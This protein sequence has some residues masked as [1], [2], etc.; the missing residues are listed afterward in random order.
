M[1]YYFSSETPSAIKVNGAFCGILSK[2]LKQINID[3]ISPFIELCPVSTCQPCVNFL[4]DNNFFCCPPS[5]VI[6]TDLDGGYLIKFSPQI[7][8]GEFKVIEQYKSSRAL[9]TVFNENGLKLSIE[10]PKDFYAETVN[11]NING[12]KIKEFD[13]DGGH[14]ISILFENDD[15]F[16]TVYEVSG[17]IRKI[18][19]RQVDEYSTDGEFFTVEKFCDMAKHQV[20]SFWEYKN[21]ALVSSR[22]ECSCDNDFNADNLNEKL[23]PYCFLE[24][25][26]TGCE[27]DKFLCGSVLQNKN[28]LGGFLGKFIGI[29]PPP[30]FRSSEEIGLI[31]TKSDNLYFVKYF[32][33]CLENRKI[34]NIIK[35]E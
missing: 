24:E 1:Y 2:D 13:L 8:S 27:W 29:M 33:F 11:F 6:L 21:G 19:F 7:I 25:Y 12:A 5:S 31:Y 10:T 34:C 23:I 22:K 17:N 18:F 15:K 4:L 3:G 32:K 16:L 14:F 26:L 20:K 28:R 30:R 35:C 9:V